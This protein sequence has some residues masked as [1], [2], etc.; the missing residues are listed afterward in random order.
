M[1]ASSCL[2]WALYQESYCCRSQKISLAALLYYDRREREA[3]EI[4]A[5]EHG[6]DLQRFKTCLQLSLVAKANRG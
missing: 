2:S 3:L 1:L 4:L 5:D 6:K